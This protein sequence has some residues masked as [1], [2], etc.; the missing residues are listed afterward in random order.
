MPQQSDAGYLL[1]GS[2]NKGTLEGVHTEPAANGAVTVYATSGG[3]T[4]KFV[5]TPI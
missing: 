5:F 1:G 2:G 3:I 4:Q